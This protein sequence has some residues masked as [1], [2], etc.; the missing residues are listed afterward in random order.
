MENKR[1]PVFKILRR[2]QVIE[3]EEFIEKPHRRIRK[4][5]RAS[6][7]S[8][9]VDVKD[10]YESLQR[11]G[12]FYDREGSLLVSRPKQATWQHVVSKSPGA[13]SEIEDSYI[14]AVEE[15]NLKAE[16]HV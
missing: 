10:L 5:A 13:D 16:E 12:P 15:I 6:L 9:S 11:F 7:D 14:S 1:R 3:L 4:L 2:N 8:D